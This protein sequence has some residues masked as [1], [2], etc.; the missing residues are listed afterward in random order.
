MTPVLEDPFISSTILLVDSNGIN[1]QTNAQFLDESSSAHTISNTS[2]STVTQGTFSPFRPTRTLGA[3]AIEYTPNIHGGSAYTVHGSELTVPMDAFNLGAGSFTIDFWVYPT[4]Q[5]S[6]SGNTFSIIGGQVIS[7]GIMWG[8]HVTNGLGYR[9][10]TFEYG[11]LG[12]YGAGKY[13]NNYLVANQWQHIVV[14]RNGTTLSIYV[15]GIR[16]TLTTYQERLSVVVTDAWEDDFNFNNTTS[17][18]SK[19]GNGSPLGASGQQPYY[20]SNVRIVKGAAL[21]TGAT[22][23]VPTALTT[24]VAGTSLLLN[25]VNGGIIDKS[26]NSVLSVIG[27]TKVS[28]AQIKYGSGSIYF[29]GTGDYLSI[30]N[31][32]L[33]NFG[34][35]D[36]TIE[37]W[38]YNKDVSFVNGRGPCMGQKRGDSKGGWVIYRNNLI[39]P[40]NLSIRL[41]GQSGANMQ[42]Y[43]TTVTPLVNTWQHWAVVR[44]GTT[45][46]WY[47]D[48]V[49][50]G[51][52]TGVST[53]ITDTDTNAP[54]YIGR[55]ET[56]GYNIPESHIDDLRITKG[57]ARYTSNFSPR[58]FVTK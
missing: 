4:L 48:G 57:V 35:G 1:T 55:A 8:I 9:G 15:N 49:A 46:T 6:T 39:N 12:V 14:Q 43:S 36:F 54:M 53:N 38:W 40:N 7:G 50:C 20:L 10:L 3:A 51:S 25:F 33:F 5:A 19:V 11:D 45:L 32:P 58:P 28:T 42:D 52:T 23:T 22:F 41:A 13:T 29:D 34:T 2:T 56:W 26:S 27:N 44:S 47:C 18:T 16:Q 17:T 21:Y 24:A 37:W 31:N 30:P